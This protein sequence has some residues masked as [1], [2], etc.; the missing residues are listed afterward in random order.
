MQTPT[1]PVACAYP[2]R[3]A[4]R[5]AR[6]GRGCAGPVESKQRVVGRQDRAARDAEHDVGADLL[7][8][9]DER[10]GAGQLAAVPRVGPWAA[11]S[12]MATAFP[13]RV[14]AVIRRCGVEVVAR[15]SPSC[16]STKGWRV[17]GDLNRSL[18]DALDEEYSTAHGAHATRRRCAEPA[19]SCSHPD[20]P[21]I[22]TERELSG[23]AGY[24]GR[25][26]GYVSCRARRPEAHRVTVAPT[27][28]G[29][30]DSK[31]GVSSSDA[32]PGSEAR[33]CPYPLDGPD[34]ALPLHATARTA[35]PSGRRS[36]A[37]PR[38]ALV[39]RAAR[40]AARRAP[41]AARRARATEAGWASSGAVGASTPSGTTHRLPAL[42]ANSR[43][44]SAAR[45]HN[46]S[47]ATARHDVPPGAAARSALGTPAEPAPAT[48][49]PPPPRTSA[50]TRIV[51]KAAVL[52]CS[53]RCTTR[54]P[55]TT[56]H[57]LNILSRAYH[58]VG[59]DVYLDRQAPQGVADRST[60]ATAEPASRRSPA[61][62][63][64]AAPR[65]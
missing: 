48:A 38:C 21:S 64:D 49:G 41:A 23:F 34:R 33:P 51:S 2:R 40:A 9:A 52:A 53:T 56:A 5:P 42:A 45:S 30:W 47:M 4:R 37:R 55:R 57:R 54:R 17:A 60:S 62:R 43:L 26:Q 35:P 39:D 28:S 1:L 14:L 15:K 44:V 10:L 65:R 50:G 58:D 7:E 3:R 59:V 31:G 24:R 16:G 46:L 13:A 22:R 12:L 29:R 63:G 36:L 6:G 18:G 11:V 19:R 32:E 20:G 8:R 61:G 27:V 25:R